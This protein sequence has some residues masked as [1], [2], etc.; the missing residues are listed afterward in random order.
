VAAQRVQHLATGG[1]DN[2][3]RVWDVTGGQ[4][5]SVRLKVSAV[6]PAVWPASTRS[7]GSSIEEAILGLG[8]GRAVLMQFAHPC[9]AKVL[10][11][12]TP[13]L[14]RPL[15]LERQYSGRGVGRL[16][17]C[18]WPLGMRRAALHIPRRYIFR[19]MPWACR[20]V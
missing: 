20:W 10:V 5:P 11:D 2:T 6:R 18:S 19:G 13:A 15:G 16:A 1:D 7:S 3:V 12:H 9:V 8:L 4:V 14:D 17:T